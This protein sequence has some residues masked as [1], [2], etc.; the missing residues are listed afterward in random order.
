MKAKYELLKVFDF[1]K[2]P[3]EIQKEIKNRFD[4]HHNNSFIEFNV[5]AEWKFE[6]DYKNG[7]LIAKEEDMIIEEGDDIISDW[8]YQNGCLLEEKIFIKI[9]W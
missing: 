2:L 8:F 1:L 9:E 5:Y 6:K 3:K 4:L 7:I